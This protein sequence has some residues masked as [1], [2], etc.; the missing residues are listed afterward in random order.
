MRRSTTIS[1]V[2]LSLLAVSLA[3]CGMH[4][5]RSGPAG[6]VGREASAPVRTDEA[7]FFER[8]AAHCG[9]AYAGRVTIDEPASV[10]APFGGKP[11]VMHVRSCDPDTIRIP[12]HVGQDRSRT[13]VITRTLTGLRLKHDHRHE[14]GTPDRSTMY[15][16]DA[17]P[18]QTTREADGALRIAFPVDAESI[19][20]FNTIGLTASVTNTWTLTLGEQRFVY[21][22]SRPDGRHFRLEFDLEHPVPSPPPPWGSADG[23]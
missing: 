11:I 4:A 1:P 12:L 3:A 19:A 18:A 9:R 6:G 22:L 21:A 14:D 16:G 17:D 5:A 23:G 7:L 8:L 2:L 15:G 20:R 13:W 10:Q